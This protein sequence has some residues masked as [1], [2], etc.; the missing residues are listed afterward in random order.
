MLFVCPAE[1]FT[2]T[3]ALTYCRNS[4]LGCIPCRV[5][6]P[7]TDLQCS[8]LNSIA[9]GLADMD[10]MLGMTSDLSENTCRTSDTSLSILWRLIQSTEEPPRKAT[11]LGIREDNCMTFGI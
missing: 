3:E 8:R 4:Y 1:N 9:T 7:D 11:G 6:L 2:E 10:K 5:A